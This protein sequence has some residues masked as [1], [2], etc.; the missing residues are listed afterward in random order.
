MQRIKW[1]LLLCWLSGFFCAHIEP[2][3]ASTSGSKKSATHFLEYSAGV[4]APQF[5]D[6]LLVPMRFSGL[7]VRLGIGWQY[8][9]RLL[10]WRAKGGIGASY[11]RERLGNQGV[12]IP[13]WFQ[14]SGYRRA[15]SHW[16]N[17]T[18]HLGVTWQSRIT[19]AMLTAWDDAHLYYLASHVVGPGT[20][21]EWS[22]PKDK[23]LTWHVHWPLLGMI[24][25]PPEERFVKQE[26]INAD[27]LF[28]KSHAHRSWATFGNYRTIGTELGIQW[29]AKRS[30]MRLSF[31]FDYEYTHFSKPLH[32]LSHR[33][34]FTQQIAIGG[35]P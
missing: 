24:C 32:S 14:L 15:F 21:V 19:S 25:R 11:L 35:A 9:G 33:L 1:L 3:Q 17:A 4:D 30:R 31:E 10:L 20:T 8:D 18:L 22:L 2:V 5:R 16:R 29:K 26:D 23:K 12:L 27:H 28:V 7:G 6:D 34:V 13:I